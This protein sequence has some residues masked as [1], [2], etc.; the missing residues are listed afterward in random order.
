MQQ[1]A[2]L[3][4]AVKVYSR[5]RDNGNSER[6]QESQALAFLVS[7]LQKAR[8][9]PSMRQ[10]YFDAL[11]YNQKMWAALRTSALD[12]EHELPEPI[13]RNM[14]SLS[15]FVDKHT[16]KL[17]KDFAPEDLDILIDINRSLSLGLQGIPPENMPAGAVAAMADSAAAELP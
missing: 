9:N 10:L 1:H 8:A 13:K 11:Y 5:T 7:Q 15:L 17:L 3:R 16:A 4:K 14:I 12:P 2:N 6:E